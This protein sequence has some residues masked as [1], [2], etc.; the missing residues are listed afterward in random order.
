MDKNFA[1]GQQYSLQYKNSKATITELAA[2]LRYLE[3]DGVQVTETHGDDV[4]A[5][6]GL[7]LVL[8]P[9]PN[10]VDKG[11]WVLD[12]KKQQLDITEYDRGHAIHGLLRNTGYSAVEQSDTSVTLHATVFPQHGYPFHLDTFVRYTLNGEGLTV[13]HRVKNLSEQKAP[14]AIGAHPYFRV[15][16]TPVED[17]EVKIA[18]GTYL[19]ADPKDMIPTE[20]KPVSGLLDLRQGQKV[21]DLDI[22]TG[23]TDITPEGKLFKHH[24]IDPQGNSTT[25]WADETMPFVHVF[26]PAGFTSDK[27]AIA[28][29]PM[30][31][32]ANAFNSGDHLQW[33][34]PGDTFTASWGVSYNKA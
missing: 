17:L 22:D 6:M 14:V 12:G 16:N 26:T 32:P 4:T 7:G 9:W 5:P 29:E 1:T 31:A 10:R 21:G 3:I 20:K 2:A 19:V 18:A 15:G 25:L 23:F 13:Q 11:Q 34:E 30:T 27:K 8:V 28:M 24:L 33:L